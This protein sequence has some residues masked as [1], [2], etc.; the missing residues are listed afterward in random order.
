MHK[1]RLQ[2]EELEAERARLVTEWQA[3]QRSA[4][5]APVLELAERS[6]SCLAPQHRWP[7]PEDDDEFESQHT[8]STTSSSKTSAKSNN[9]KDE[10]IASLDLAEAWSLRARGVLA[11][12]RC[13]GG[14]GGRAAR[15][16]RDRHLRAALTSLAHTLRI[17]THILLNDGHHTDGGVDGDAN[18]KP[19]AL[20]HPLVAETQVGSRVR[21]SISVG[22]LAS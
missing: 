6:I 15:K 7:Q 19:S 14:G 9:S 8:A 4:W 21:A 13:E 22:K 11:L 16:R 5:V 10:D 18:N 3:A 12:L 17:Q 1:K 20:S 2:R